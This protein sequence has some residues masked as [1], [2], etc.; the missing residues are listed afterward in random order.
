M[1]M[2]LSLDMAAK[3]ASNLGIIIVVVVLAA[4]FGYLIYIWY[5]N[6]TRYKEFVCIIWGKDAFGNTTESYDKAGVFVFKGN[7]RLWL[8]KNK[9]GLS[10]DKVP[11]IEG[12][13]KKVYLLKKGTGNFVYVDPEVSEK[14][15]KFNVGEDDLNWGLHTYNVSKE[16]FGKNTWLTYAPFILTAIA[17]LAVIIVAYF[18]TKKM[19]MFVEVS[20]NALQATTVTAEAIKELAKAQA[21][22]GASVI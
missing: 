13:P 3:A 6:Y 1:A 2:G 5:K 20:Q 4:A 12:K 16:T 14:D 21:A 15:L 22:Q 8:Q 18:L 9:V 19:D 10:A 7:K 11:Y 17:I